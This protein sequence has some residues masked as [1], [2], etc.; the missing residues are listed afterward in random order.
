MIHK[1]N[2]VTLNF[3]SIKYV[4]SSKDID[5]GIKRPISEWEKVFAQ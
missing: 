2:N 3:I 5:V 4:W 1:W